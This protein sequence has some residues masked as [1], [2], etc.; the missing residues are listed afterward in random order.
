[1]FNNLFKVELLI[2]NKSRILNSGIIFL[3]L[4]IAFQIY[5]SANQQIESLKQQ[6]EYELK[7]NKVSEDI[8][9]L[10]KRIEGY[11]KN[12]VKKEM[13]SVMD[14]LSNIAKNSSVKISSIRPISDEAYADYIKSSFLIT[15]SAP[16]YHSLVKFISGVESYKDIYFV[17]ELHINMVLAEAKQFQ[18][19]IDKDLKV[20]L[21]V[22]TISYL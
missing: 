3:A 4:I 17:E 10:E 22:S 5:K 6:Q 1:M 11:K 8:A 12:L 16:D 21:K 9:A 20:S 18:G 13:G 15:V 7:K 2:K 19:T 14:S